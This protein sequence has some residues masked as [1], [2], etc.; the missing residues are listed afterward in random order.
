[1]ENKMN[2]YKKFDKIKREIKEKSLGIGKDGHADAGNFKHSFV[3][4]EKLQPLVDDVLK[5]NNVVAVMPIGV[6]QITYT[7][8]D[9]DSGEKLEITIPMVLKGLQKGS[10]AQSLGAS[11]TYMRRYTLGTVYELNFKDEAEKEKSL[12]LHDISV[13]EKRTQ[14]LYTDKAKELGSM[15]DVAKSMGLTS[16]KM[17][18]KFKLFKEIRDFENKLKKVKK[19]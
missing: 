3:T 10:E 11:L 15:K 9:L 12:E 19:V 8:V 6:E 5:E 17:S 16:D 18:D 2:M 4:L 14:I 13:I 1:M 7:L